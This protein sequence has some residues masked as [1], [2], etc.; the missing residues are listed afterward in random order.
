MVL[1]EIQKFEIISKYYNLN[2]SMQKIA[3]QMN[4]SRH[5]VSLWI[6]RYKKDKNLERKRGSGLYNDHKIK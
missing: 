3:D 1:S 6:N 5:T 2:M 4:I